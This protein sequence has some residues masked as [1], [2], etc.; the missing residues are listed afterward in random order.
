M[1]ILQKKLKIVCIE[2]YVGCRR[3]S[4]EDKINER[5]DFF[6]NIFILLCLLFIFIF[7]H[8][9]IKFLSTSDEIITIK[10]W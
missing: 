7:I 5:F 1:E 9:T 8:L 6:E 4:R 3:M 2:V 10:I